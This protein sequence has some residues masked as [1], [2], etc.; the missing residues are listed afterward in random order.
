MEVFHILAGAVVGLI[1]GLTG[2]GGGSLMTP[3]LVLGFGISPYVAVGTDLLYA[4]ITK[5][6]GVFFHHKHK[7][8]DWNIVWLLASGSIPSSI[9]TILCLEQIRAKGVGY[10][11][12]MMLTLSFML[13]LTAIIIVA[14]NKILNYVHRQVTPNAIVT[15]LRNI[16]PQLT[17][18]SGLILGILVTISSV[19][20]GAIGSA[21][22]FL[23]YPRKKAI[24]IVG[25]DIAHAVPLTAIA[26]LGHTHFGSVNFGLL[27]GLLSGGIPAIYLGS[28]IGKRLPDNVFRPIIAI[29][30]FAMGIKLVINY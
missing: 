15:I 1:I 26:G 24:A 3:L 17:I 5:C 10:D 27:V 12:L 4:S 29:I 2:V 18:C 25:T 23:L 20:A 28:I 19:G 11:Q 9:V 7:T 6:G 8:V 30:L 22:L 13:I 14:K 21:I 16:R